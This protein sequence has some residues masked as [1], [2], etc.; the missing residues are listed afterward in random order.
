LLGQLAHANERQSF[1]AKLFLDFSRAHKIIIAPAMSD[2]DLVARDDHTEGD[3]T[4]ATSKSFSSSSSQDDGDR[5]NHEEWLE[6]EE[7]GHSI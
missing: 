6:N 3:F 7:M 4:L 1:L 2:D 5:N